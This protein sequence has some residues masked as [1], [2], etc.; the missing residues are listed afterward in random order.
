MFYAK[1]QLSD[2]VVVKV[3]AKTIDFSAV[4][5]ICGKEFPIDASEYFDVSEKCGEIHCED[6]TE[7]M[8]PFIIQHPERD[9]DEYDWLSM[10]TRSE[11]PSDLFTW[12]LEHA[13]HEFLD[14]AADQFMA[15]IPGYHADKPLSDIN[16]EIARRNKE[17]NRD[18]R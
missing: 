10:L 6:C 11:Y 9:Y 1:I 3:D 14:A 16:D 5:P 12:A 18:D 17:A 7:Q 2:E 13:P 15:M 8:K 4:C